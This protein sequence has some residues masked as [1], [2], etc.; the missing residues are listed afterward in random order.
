[1][2]ACI[3][4]DVNAAATNTA[5][6][7]RSFADTK[8]KKTE[9]YLTSTYDGCAI[10]LQGLVAAA[11]HVAAAPAERAA[12]PLPPT[13]PL[14][15][16]L[17]SRSTCS[18]CSI[19]TTTPPAVSLSPCLPAAALCLPASLLQHLQYSLPLLCLHAAAPAA[20][21]HVQYLQH[22]PHSATCS[23]PVSL[24]P[25]CS[26]LPPRLP[27]ATPAIQ[28]SCLPAATPAVQSPCLP[29]SL[30]QRQQRRLHEGG[31]VDGQSCLFHKLQ[32]LQTKISVW[33]RRTREA[34]A[35]SCL[36]VN[37]PCQQLIHCSASNSTNSSK[38][39]TAAAGIGQ[40]AAASATAAADQ[41]GCCERGWRHGATKQHSR[42]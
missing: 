35:I 36:P 8:A 30:L 38:P 29:A 16:L 4:G 15:A 22:L 39:A 40:A 10:P 28:S 20:R 5:A 19:C 42:M 31:K 32:N 18:T 33:T 6:G 37:R 11:A 2:T 12:S 3:G 13:T 24:P 7:F 26:S 27:E 21:H 14:L 1:M 9:N 17:L 41:R 23:L 34:G 25:C